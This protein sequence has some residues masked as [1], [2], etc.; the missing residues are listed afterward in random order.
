MNANIGNL[1]PRNLGDMDI[2]KPGYGDCSNGGISSKFTT[3]K[4]WSDFDKD[5][6][7]NAVVIIKDTCCGEPRI[8]A[9]PANKQGKWDMFGGCFIYTS[10]GVVPHSGTPIKLHD[11]FED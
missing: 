7:E 3:V 11:R 8:R 4:I 1:K 2:Y 9:V 10:N 6:P 5:A